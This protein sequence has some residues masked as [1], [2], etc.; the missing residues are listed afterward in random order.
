MNAN[1]ILG[2]RA[3]RCEAGKR[4]RDATRAAQDRDAPEALY[5]YAVTHIERVGGQWWAHNGEYSSMV[6][7]CPWCGVD[8]LVEEPG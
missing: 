8:L 7:F 6:R 4:L 3:H 2:D 1:E 5:G